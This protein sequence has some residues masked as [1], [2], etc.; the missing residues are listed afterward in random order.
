[1]A[2]GTDGFIKRVYVIRN[3]V[4]KFKTSE[5][6]IRKEPYKEDLKL[7]PWDILCAGSPPLR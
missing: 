4:V 1:M 2:D 3:G 5:R 7:L 6:R